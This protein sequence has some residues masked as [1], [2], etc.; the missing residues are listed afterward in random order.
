VFVSSISTVEGWTATGQVSEQS[1]DDLTL[2]RMGYCRSKLAGSLILD[3]A[4]AYFGVPTASVRVGQVAGPRGQKGA[5]NRREF[6]PSPSLIASS[7]HLGMLPQHLSTQDVF[8]WMPVKD[9]AGLVLDIA[10]HRCL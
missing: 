9:V 5:W 1:I 3:A 7:V 2:P 8:D 10:G 4:T 6:L